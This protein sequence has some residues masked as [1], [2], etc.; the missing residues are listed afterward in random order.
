MLEEE[1]L[2]TFSPFNDV[3]SVHDDITEIVNKI[4]G[5]RAYTRVMQRIIALGLP[6]LKA[7]QSKKTKSVAVKKVAFTDDDM[8]T[9]QYMFNLILNLNPNHLEPNFDSWA[10]TVRLMRERNGKTHR[11]ICQVFKWANNDPFWQGNILSHSKL[12][13]KFDE[14]AVK[15]NSAPRSKAKI[16]QPTLTDI[17]NDDSVRL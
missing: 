8:T 6:L 11:E 9:A 5:K 12:R 3:K 4:G 1:S 7:E 17:M 16:S 15:M 10:D 2:K 13:D 14:L